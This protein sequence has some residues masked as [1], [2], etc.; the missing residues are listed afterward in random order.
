MYVFRRMGMFRFP[1]LRFH[2]PSLYMLLVSDNMFRRILNTLNS[3]YADDL[4]RNTTICSYAHMRFALL[5][6]RMNRWL[7]M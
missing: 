2:A 1:T 6:I 5:R 4:R 3:F 7:C